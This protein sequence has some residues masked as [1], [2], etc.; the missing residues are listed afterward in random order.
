MRSCKHATAEQDGLCQIPKRKKMHTTKGDIAPTSAPATRLESSKL[1][2]VESTDLVEY[3]NT[4]NGVERSARVPVI[5]KHREVPR[6]IE[7]LMGRT[8]SHENSA[9]ATCRGDH[10][11]IQHPPGTRIVEHCA[12]NKRLATSG[13]SK[14]QTTYG[15]NVL[16]ISVSPVPI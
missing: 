9:T 5:S 8:T 4:L 15:R 2:S 16:V 10:H 14:T 1:L 13:T 7:R 3:V 12:D 11:G 6:S